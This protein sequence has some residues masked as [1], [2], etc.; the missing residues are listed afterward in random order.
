MF[1]LNCVS[2]HFLSQIFE[3][4]AIDLRR[5]LQKNSYDTFMKVGIDEV[6]MLTG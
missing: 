4:S 2:Y 6:S 3:G 1:R 5:H